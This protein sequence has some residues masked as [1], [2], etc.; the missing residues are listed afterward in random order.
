MAPMTRAQSPLGVPTPA[1]ADYYARRAAAGVGLIISEGTGVRRPSSLNEPNAPR[2]HGSD[3][4]EGWRRTLRGVHAAGGRMAPQIWHVGAMPHVRAEWASP[5]PLDSPS[6]LV[7]PDEPCGE[8]MT[9]SEIAD[10]IK[11]F[12]DAAAEA[13][14]LGFDAIEIHGAHGY[15][16][17][18]FFWAGTNRR[19]D[20]YGGRDLT[21]RTRFAVDVIRAMRTRMPNEMPLILRISQFK[22]QDYLVKLAADPNELE[23]WLMPLAEA[24][25]TIFHCSQRRFWEAEFEGSDLNLAGW[26][27]RVTGRPTITVGSIGLARDVATAYQGERSPPAPLA[28]VI[29]RLERGDFDLVAIGR[30][31]LQDPNWA[32]KVAS[33]LE[34]DLMD[35]DP[36]SMRVLT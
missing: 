8:P 18:Q 28:E 7:S 15:L 35:F 2:F 21:A 6:G 11:A 12:A 5:D 34:A 1:M 24:G 9:D 31:L 16:I 33:G 32:A 17:D 36:A 19:L 25:V 20:A 13:V 26:V 22:Q 23:R 10:T 4:L 30:A 29:R 3:A 27:K 14:A